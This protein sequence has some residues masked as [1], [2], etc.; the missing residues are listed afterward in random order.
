M[1][2]TISAVDTFS[3]IFLHFCGKLGLIFQVK[4]LLC[5]LLKVETKFKSC[6]LHATYAFGWIQYFVRP[7]LGPNCL[8]SSQQTTLAGEDLNI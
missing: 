6:S 8:Q 1:L 4:C 3:E 2:I 7:D 5:L